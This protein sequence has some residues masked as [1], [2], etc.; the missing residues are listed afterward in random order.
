MHENTFPASISLGRINTNQPPNRNI[1]IKVK[2]NI[3]F[4][5]TFFKRYSRSFLNI[6][7]LIYFALVLLQLLMLNLCAIIGI[8][9]MEFFKFGC[10]KR[11]KGK[12]HLKNPSLVQLGL[13]LSPLKQKKLIGVTCIGISWS[14]F[15]T[16]F[17]TF[18]K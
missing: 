13:Y 1:L 15:S 4:T 14:T 18:R 2:V 5:R 8:W 10:T 9:K 11:F 6:F 7:R 3:A 16:L 12:Q 17:S